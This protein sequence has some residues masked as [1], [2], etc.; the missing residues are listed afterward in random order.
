MFICK[1]YIK[2]NNMIMLVGQVDMTWSHTLFKQNIKG[3]LIK[4]TWIW[5]LNPKAMNDSTKPSKTFT[6]KE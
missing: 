4:F 3:G 1:N 2:P 6:S 5:S